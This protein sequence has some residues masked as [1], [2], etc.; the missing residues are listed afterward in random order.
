MTAGTPT[1]SVSMLWRVF[2]ANAAVFALAF[3]LLTLSPVTI[4]ARI[5][6]IELAI[7]LAGLIVMLLVD[8]VL[9][10]EALRPLAQLSAVMAQIDLQ[11]PGQR[12][13]GFEHSS[14]EVCGLADAFN[15]ML[16]RLEE[17]R[18]DSSGRVLAAQEAERLRIARELHDEVGQTLT[19]AALRAEQAAGQSGAGDPEFAE[20]AQIVHRSLDDLRRIS[21]ELRPAALEPLGLMNALISLGA[22]VESEGLMRVRREL[23]GPLP[24][25]PPDVELTIYRIAQE[26]LT[27]AI[28]H[29]GSAEV[30]VSLRR[31]G[32]AVVLAVI[33]SGR[34]LPDDVSEGGGLIGMRERAM[35]IGAALEV[36][37]SSGRGVAVTLRVPTGGS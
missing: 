23:E 28:R 20:L 36:G 34:G 25:L 17:E 4:H 27:N 16:E 22:R 24:D 6:L 5:R 32:D 10:R 33:D 37:S 3:A 2:A 9:L 12:A 31:S 14:T 13:V 29:S 1:R 30:V 18:R 19:A 7:L 15:A 11:R 26:A 35:L 21:H 8:L